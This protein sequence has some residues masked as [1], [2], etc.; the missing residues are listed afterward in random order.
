MFQ[1]PLSL[2]CGHSVCRCVAGV[3]VK[4]SVSV[5]RC[6]DVSVCRCQCRCRYWCRYWCQCR[7]SGVGVG[8]GVTGATNTAGGFGCWCCVV[9]IRPPSISILFDWFFNF[10]LFFFGY[11]STLASHTKQISR[12]FHAFLCN[13]CVSVSGMFPIIPLFNQSVLSLLLLLFITDKKHV[14]THTLMHTLTP[15]SHAHCISVHPPPPSTTPPSHVHQH[16]YHRKCAQTMLSASKLRCRPTLAE[17]IKPNTNT[18]TNNNNN[19]NNASEKHSLSLSCPECAQVTLLP[20]P[21]HHMHHVHNNNNND[22]DA[23]D[24]ALLLLVLKPNYNLADCVD[25]YIKGFVRVRVRE[26]VCLYMFFVCYKQ[27]TARID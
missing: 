18:D 9:S 6:V 15:T 19:N 4:L 26:C 24:K 8:G 16:H 13:E 5:C 17:H 23:G 11:F 1:E 10:D 25:R 14:Q 2:P 3:G 27:A 7:C 20:Y 12:T 21:H 22:T